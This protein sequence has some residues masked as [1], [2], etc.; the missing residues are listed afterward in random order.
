[1]SPLWHETVSAR[2]SEV[3]AR[4]LA[5][6]TSAEVAKRRLDADTRKPQPSSIAKED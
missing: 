1:M 6:Q 2:I 3:L 5:R 4:L